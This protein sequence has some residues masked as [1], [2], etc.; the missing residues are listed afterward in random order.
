[1]PGLADET[2]APTQQ[3]REEAE[4]ERRL[5]QAGYNDWQAAALVEA[6][7]DCHLAVKLLEQGCDPEVAVDIL[8]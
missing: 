5:V 3:E 4:L 1:V 7:V 6:R 2:R 8:L